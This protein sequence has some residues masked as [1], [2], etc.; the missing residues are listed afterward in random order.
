MYYNIKFLKILYTTAALLILL[1]A[2]QF[3][4]VYKNKNLISSL[5]SIKVKEIKPASQIYEIN[6]KNELDHILCDKKVDINKYILDWSIERRF[7]ELIK[8]ETNFTRRFE[9]TLRIKF[10]L[11]DANNNIIYTDEIISK[12]A[13]NIL[14]DEII[15]TKASKESLNTA[16]AL[17]AARLVLDKIYLFMRNK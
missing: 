1:N 10:N 4:P 15:S 3:E 14:E 7:K 13:Y 2:C 6:F 11:L 5:C 16:I 12:G 8:S 17:N 9:E